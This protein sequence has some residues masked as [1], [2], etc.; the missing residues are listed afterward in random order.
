MD[1]DP[2][3]DKNGNY[4]SKKTH[5]Y[6][7]QIMRGLVACSLQRSRH[8]FTKFQKHFSKKSNYSQESLRLWLL[9][10]EM[11]LDYA[12]HWTEQSENPRTIKA[13]R[14]LRKR[15]YKFRASRVIFS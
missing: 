12:L 9:A 6:H 3:W 11:T 15:A 10:F 7:S 13:V 14:N 5:C 8:F 2:D 1:L 4:I